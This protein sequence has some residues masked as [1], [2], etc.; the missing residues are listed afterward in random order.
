MSG[1]GAPLSV[2]F[3]GNVDHG[4]S[5]L[6]ARLL[7]DTGAFPEGR[8]DELVRAA[9]RRGIAL[10]LSFLLDALQIERDQAITVDASR[11]WFASAARRYAIVDAPGHGALVRNMISG[12]A[13]ARAA[14]LVIDASDGVALQ[15]RRHASLLAL[16]GVGDV[17]V[18]VNKIDLADDAARF[19][20]I[21][22]AARD[23]L[24]RVGVRCAAVV[25]TVARDGDAVVRRGDRFAW[26]SGPT[27]LEALD[28]IEDRAEDDGRAPMRLTVQDVY[29]RDGRRIV[30]G[31]LCAGTARVGQEIVIQPSGER[32]T[33]ERFVTF[34][35]GGVHE[36]RAG[37][38]IA[39][40]LASDAFVQPGD[41]VAAADT[42]A[43]PVRAFRATTFC[44]DADG[45]AADTPLQL[46][47]GTRDTPVTVETIEGRI[48]FETLD[49]GDAAS[50]R[51]NDVGVAVFSALEA[52]VV[53]PAVDAL[54]RF[55]LYRGGRIVGGGVVLADG[56]VRASVARRRSPNVS[57]VHAGGT[58]ALGA[59]LGQ[60]GAVLWLTGLPASGK[61]TLAAG[62]ARRLIAA[63]R[64]AYVLDGDSLRTGLNGDL[65]FSESDRA[66]NIRRTAEVA[67]LFA[68]AGIVTICAT[69]SPKTADR[70][71]AREICGGAFYEVFVE[72]DVATCEARDPKGLYR[73]A[74]AG[75]LAN[76]TGVSAPYEIPRAPDLRIASGT[77]SAEENAALLYTFAF[78]KSEA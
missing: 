47:I 56:L 1:D 24:A 17:V 42:P 63:G 4:K 58:H 27:L 35:D 75:D 53:D 37:S 68:N 12:A 15:T 39:L 43:H 64:M 61:S 28:A 77:L 70:E 2:V 6:I 45:F 41:V 71:R 13:D 14:V 60:R 11:L 21:E 34:P 44:L 65:G 7:L 67:A 29:R 3:T 30:A 49:A 32:A 59:L 9:Q 55:A 73:R 22:G 20:A 66:E 8:Y 25:P 5:T 74:R 52:T 62:A 46:R 36:L 50:L 69:I 16:L 23:V 33:I 51:E 57:A 19:A 72:A 18:A 40:V 26:Y 10:E 54:K 38:Q 76:F 31:E 48:D 78:E